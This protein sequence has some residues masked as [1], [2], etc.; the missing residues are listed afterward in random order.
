VGVEFLVSATAFREIEIEVR[1]APD[2]IETGGVLLGTD[3]AGVV[4]VLHAGG[5]GPAAVQTRTSLLRDTLHSQWLADDAWARDGSQWIGEWHTHPLGPS[6]P[7]DLDLRS[8]AAHLLDPTLGFHRFYAIIVTD[9]ASGAI[10]LNSWALVRRDT[11]TL[12][13]TALAQIVETRTPNDGEVPE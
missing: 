8:Y 5:P 9:L 4:K 3:L 2:G 12:E 6:T 13:L 10:T 11:K 1:A 7:S